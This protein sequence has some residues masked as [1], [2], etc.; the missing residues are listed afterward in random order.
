MVTTHHRGARAGSPANDLVTTL[1]SIIIVA[2]LALIAGLGFYFSRRQSTT[3][4]YF[5][6]GRSL[7]GWVMGFSLLGT[8]IGSATFVG[9]PG[10]VFQ[11]DMWLLPN[12]LVLPI[13]MIFVARYLVRFYRHS[14]GLSAYAYL[15]AR[16][17]YLARAYGS[18]SFI[19][20]RVVDVAS[21]FFF[22]AVTIAALTDF[23]L[24]PVIVTVG[25]ITV[26]YTLIGGIQAVV[27]S[28][29][30]QGVLLVTGGLVLLTSV[31]LAPG[32]NPSQL[33]ATAWQGGKF[34]WGSIEPSFSELNVWMLIVGGIFWALQRYACDQHMVQR[35]LLAKSDREAVRGAYL[36]AVACVPVWFLFMVVGALLWAYYELNVGTLPEEVLAEADRV[37]PFFIREHFP[38]GLVGLI[39]AALI[40]AAMST[41]DSDLNSLAAVVVDDFYA[42]LLPQSSDAA[43]LLVGRAV[44]CLFGSIAIFFSLQFVGV[45]ALLET[46][47]TMFTW[48]GAGML[49]LFALGFC[50]PR[51]NN[52]GVLAGIIACTLFTIWAAG[53]SVTLPQWEKPLLDFG[54]YNYTLHV[55][56]IGVLG[57]LVMIIVGIIV[58]YLTSPPPPSTF[59][60]TIWSTPKDGS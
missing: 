10:N 22:L 34:G 27:W 41:L 44:V 26:L 5:L 17:G 57:H 6:A 55:F 54:P 30:V 3:D 45:R 49:G 39:V 51:A 11:S 60:F 23:E 50:V 14:V 59:Q 18:L 16:F 29:V 7:P 31:L 24:R 53:T 40:A 47:M 21:T 38:S 28:D 4:E 56:I 13:V 33:F 36:G 8:M 2:Y 35:Y 19:I 32:A 37:V 52:W 20:S 12:H 15:E 1:D 42:K 9:H 43:R 48:A 46:T 25:T 58:S